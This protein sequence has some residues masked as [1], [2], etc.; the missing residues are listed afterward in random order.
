MHF[1][2]I[3]AGIIDRVSGFGGCCAEC[4]TF[5]AVGGII[6][7]DGLYEY[8]NFRMKAN[9]TAYSADC[10]KN[11]PDQRS[12]YNYKRM[13]VHCVKTD[14]YGSCRDPFNKISHEIWSS[15]PGLRKE[16]KRR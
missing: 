16:F 4:T 13:L 5:N 10:F 7:S 1:L 3:Q 9:A 11:D 2:T 14:P 12:K 15:R 6:C 8:L